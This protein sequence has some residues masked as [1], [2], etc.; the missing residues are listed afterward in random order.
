M[1]ERL[2]QN[3][4][5]LIIKPGVKLIVTHDYM[6]NKSML[7]FLAKNTINVFLYEDKHT[8]GCPARL[9]TPSRFKGPLPFLTT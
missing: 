4:K 3:A 9:T 2:Q 1:Q 8:G 5:L 6:D 7:D